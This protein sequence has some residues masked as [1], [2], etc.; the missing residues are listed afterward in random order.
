MATPA[1]RYAELLGEIKQ[2]NPIGVSSDA[3]TRAQ[4]TELKTSLSSIEQI[5]RELAGS[6]TSTTGRGKKQPT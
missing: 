6:D 2:R 5:E 4:P 1:P 3:L